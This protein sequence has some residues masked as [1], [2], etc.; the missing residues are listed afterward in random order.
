VSGIGGPNL[1][2]IAAAFVG[3]LAAFPWLP[4]PYFGFDQS[5]LTRAAV[6]FLIPTAAFVICATIDTLFIRTASTASHLE[7]IKAMRTVS[8]ATVLFLIGLHGLVLATLL[9]FPMP[10]IPAHRLTVVLFGLLLIAIGNVLPRVRPNMA[11]GIRTRSLLED[12]VAWARVH[13]AAGY[14][15]VALGAVAAGAGLVLSK[16]QIP[17]VLS[18]SVLAGAIANLTAYRRWTRG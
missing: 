17:L 12:P 8:A 10:F 5:L 14:S 15:L 6:A 2:L 3:G 4:G 7:S 11:I 9:G 1:L 16:S 18:A 13:R